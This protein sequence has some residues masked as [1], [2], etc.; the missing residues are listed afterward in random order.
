VNPEQ[1][2]YKLILAPYDSLLLEV[3]RYESPN[4]ATLGQNFLQ[5]KIQ[6]GRRWCWNS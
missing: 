5:L 4:S 3:S 1:I 2:C 6:D